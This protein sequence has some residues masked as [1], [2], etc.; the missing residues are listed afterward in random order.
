MS[1]SKALLDYIL[2]VKI[3]EEEIQQR[4]NICNAKNEK[5]NFTCEYRSK[6]EPAMCNKCW[7]FLDGDLGKWAAPR[8]VCP[9]KKW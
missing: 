7:C 9:L 3:S 8:A 2:G 4:K 6:G 5:G 1:F